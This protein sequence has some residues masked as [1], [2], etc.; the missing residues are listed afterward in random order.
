MITD[1]VVTGGLFYSAVTCAEI[2]DFYCSNA[3]GYPRSFD[4]LLIAYDNCY[5]MVGGCEVFLV[6]SSTNKNIGRDDLVT[7]FDAK[8][9]D[10][11]QGMPIP[12]VL[13]MNLPKH[14]VPPALFC[15][16]HNDVSR[17][18]PL[19]IFVNGGGSVLYVPKTGKGRRSKIK[20][21]RTSP[22]V[23]PGEQIAI[24]AYRHANGAKEAA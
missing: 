22:D 7:S 20:M 4:R 19:T 8:R 13:T 24:A 10:I 21:M 17:D 14:N 5:G 9:A 1:E 18:L 6:S 3:V 12:L 15:W 16:A 2:R 11:L 23:K